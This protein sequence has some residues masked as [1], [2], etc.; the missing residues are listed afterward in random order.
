MRINFSTPVAAQ[1]FTVCV[2]GFAVALATRVV[3]QEPDAPTSLKFHFATVAK[4]VDPDPTKQDEAAR[5]KSLRKAISGANALLENDQIDRFFEEYINPFWFAPVVG[6]P[7]TDTVDSFFSKAVRD[8]PARRKDF[9]ER[10]GRTLKA[11][12]QAEPKWL[13]NG[14]A[15][16]FMTRPNSHHTA[17]FWVYFDGKWRISPET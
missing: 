14:R 13:L 2:V 12:L 6:T 9:V 8:N 7:G 16:S 11:S 1:F 3:A 5:V 15:A 17:E 10:F 4:P